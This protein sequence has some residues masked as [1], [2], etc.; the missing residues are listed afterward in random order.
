MSEDMVELLTA[1]EFLTEIMEHCSVSD[2]MCCC[3]DDMANHASPMDCGHTPVDHGQYHADGAYRKAKELLAKH[4]R[5]TAQ[6]LSQ[7][8]DLGEGE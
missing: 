6:P 8:P 7:F 1:L 3:G 5:G 2:G 4:G